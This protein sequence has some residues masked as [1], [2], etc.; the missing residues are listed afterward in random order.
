MDFVCIFIY[1]GPLGMCKTFIDHHA[2]LNKTVI[3]VLHDKVTAN[4]DVYR[5]ACMIID[6]MAIKKQICFAYKSQKMTEFV[7]LRDGQAGGDCT[8]ATEILVFMVVRSTHRTLIGKLLYQSFTDTN[9]GKTGGVHPGCFGRSRGLCV[10]NHNVWTCKKLCNVQ[11]TWLRLQ[12]GK[13]Q[14]IIQ[15]CQNHQ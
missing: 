15:A 8:E 9:T 2:G 7:D 4:P 6:T 10:V 5:N 12:G 11:R 1:L 14:T 13:Y 3:G